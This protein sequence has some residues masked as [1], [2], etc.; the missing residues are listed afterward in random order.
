MEKLMIEEIINLILPVVSVI[1]GWVLLN[2]RKFLLSKINNETYRQLADTVFQK[3]IMSVAIVDKEVV[4]PARKK[5][6]G[7]LPDETK[8][9]AKNTAVGYFV[10]SLSQQEQQFFVGKANNEIEKNVNMILEY[11]LKQYKRQEWER[12]SL[13]N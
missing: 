2:I 9:I 4:K 3:A 5:N 10:N 1:G 12:K 8:T 11:A 7:Y 13:I 6:K